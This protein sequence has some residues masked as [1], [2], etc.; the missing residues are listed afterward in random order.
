MIVLDTHA[1]IWMIDS[2]ALLGK[3][4]VAAIETARIE[5]AIYI[6][7]ISAWEIYMLHD[8]GRLQFSI[9]PDVWISR[10]ERLSFLRFIPVDNEI[11]RLS[12]HLPGEFH[13]DPADRIIV[14][15]AKFMG[16]TVV[17]QDSKIRSYKKVTSAW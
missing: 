14:A 11:A 4:A 10:C 8:K 16:A 5:N 3:K 13:A 2:P 1:W 9:A 17:T 7:S 15:T 12:V 6:S